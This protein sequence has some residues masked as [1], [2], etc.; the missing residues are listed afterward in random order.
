MIMMTDQ[1]LP[2]QHF[3]RINQ[4]T[5]L[6]T[7]VMFDIIFEH[8]VLRTQRY[9]SP[10]SLLAI[11][12]TQESAASAE[13]VE[14]AVRKVAHIL[15]TGLRAVDVPVF[16]GSAFLVLLPATNETGACV[17]GNR[18]AQEINGTDLIADE[19]SSHLQVSL[20]L[21]THP[22]GPGISEKVMIEQALQALAIARQ[23]GP[24][25]LVSFNELLPYPFQPVK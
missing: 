23:R 8:E 4:T 15:N 16:K 14:A 1:N 22:G 9:P 7:E 10:I 13:T 11:A 21:S 20:G 6:F 24:G 5:G 12:W 25:A 2:T 18:L 17:A 19:N 3:D